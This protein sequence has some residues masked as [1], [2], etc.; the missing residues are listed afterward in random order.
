M[1]SHCRKAIFHGLQRMWSDTGLKLW[2]RSTDFAVK[3]I[4]LCETI[5]EHDSLVNQLERSSTSIGTNLH[6]A[7]CAH[8]RAD[9][10]AKLQIALEECYETEYWLALFVKS[11][12]VEQDAAKEWYRQCGRIRKRLIRRTDASKY[13]IRQFSAVSFM[14]FP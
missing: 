9:F 1:I 10:T 2:D 14:P 5:R 3:I 6:E 8:G 4:K 12:L 7:N 13:H 11:E